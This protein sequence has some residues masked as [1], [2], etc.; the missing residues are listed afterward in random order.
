MLI[1]NKYK[2]RITFILPTFSDQIFA[3]YV[4]HFNRNRIVSW[5]WYVLLTVYC[6]VD[7]VDIVHAMVEL[8]N[9]Y[10]ILRD[11]H[12]VNMQVSSVSFHMRY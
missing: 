6:V 11:D 3:I 10:V 12:Y 2:S 8:F 1:N 4:I 7:D 9:V 5:W